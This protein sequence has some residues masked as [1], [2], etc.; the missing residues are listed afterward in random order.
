[1]NRTTLFP[2]AIQAQA[3]AI[4]AAS[5]ARFGDDLLRMELPVLPS[6]E[7]LTHVRNADNFYM[8]RDERAAE[9]KK[10][11]AQTWACMKQIMDRAD[12]E[13]RDLKASEIR[14]YDKAEALLN[15][16]DEIYNENHIDRRGVVAPADRHEGY[17]EGAPLAADQTFVGAM[18][19]L[20]RIPEAHDSDAQLSLGKYL[21][22]SLTGRWDGAE[23]ELRVANAL[24]G[25]TSAAGGILIPEILSGEIVDKARAQ[26][27]VVQAG[28]RVV[29]MANRKVTV[30]KW[31]T[32]PVPE[33]RAENSA[34]AEDDAG[35]SSLELNAKGLGVVTKVSLELLEDTDIQGELEA[36]FA[37]SFAQV[38]DLAALY[39]DGTDDAQGNPRPTGVRYQPGVTVTPAAANGATPT[40][41]TLVSSV[42]RVRDA[43]EDPTAQIMADRTART[44]AMLTGSDGQYVAA[45]S[46]LDGV[47]RLT[48]SQVPTNLDEG[49]T[50]D[51]TSDLFTADWAKLLIG[52]RSE[53]RIIV[54]NQRYLP[55]SGQIGFLCHWR[56]DFAVTR[57]AAFDVVTGLTA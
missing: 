56:G 30:P 57:P 35:M 46:Y 2:A 44:L 19:A 41:A 11:R 16:L 24:S 42:G 52:V 49:T 28:A 14:T 40:W 8:K 37:R 27:R 31:V 18:R 34:F 50:L 39:A 32:D 33:W 55:D 13:G 10:L 22:G 23:D 38:L 4:L 7:Q 47:Q 45:P 36:A 21:R 53:L 3:D 1:M 20:N 54:L 29:P 6:N 51:S 25:A 43:N 5:K 48:T 17:R 26:T 12:S 15:E 9:A